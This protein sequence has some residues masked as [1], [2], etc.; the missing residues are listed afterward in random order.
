MAN[1]SP[2][3]KATRIHAAVALC[4]ASCASA[5]A[6][7]T[8]TEI[9]I[10]DKLPARVSGFGDVSAQELPFSTT[11]ITSATLQ[12]IGAQR[13]SDA[14]RLDAS[15]SDSYNSPAY[16]DILSVRGFTLDNRYNYRREGLPI[17]AETMIPMDN[18][19]R[20]E[21]LKGTS[22]IQAGTSSPGGLVNYVVKRAPTN[23][24]QQIR[25]ITLSYGQ[26]NNGLVAADL[27]GRFGETAEFGYRLNIAHED[28][29]PYIRNTKGQRNL[30]ALAMDWRLK[31]GTVVDFEFEQSHREQIGINGYSLL[32]GILPSPVDP[33]VNL[34]R[35]SWSQ[36]GVFDAMTG[37]IRLRQE[38]DAGWSWTTQYGAQRLKT[39]DRLAFGFG[40]S[41]AGDYSQYCADGSFDL[42]DFR[43]ENERRLTDAFQTQLSGK[44]KLG[45]LQ[46]DLVLGY[47]RQRQLD[48]MPPMQSYNYNATASVFNPFTSTPSPSYVT[49]NTNRSEY[50]TEFSIKDRM[51]LSTATSLWTGLRHVNYSRSSEQNEHADPVLGYPDLY[52]NAKQFKGSINVPWIAVSTQLQGLVAYAS[53]GH[54]VE[55]FVTPNTAAYGPNAGAQLGIGRSRQTEVGLRNLHAQYKLEWSAAVFQISRP[56]AHDLFDGGNYSTR[57]IDGTQTH[58]G[59]DIGA[60]WQKNQWKLSTQ[61][62]WMY[63]KLS[64]MQLSPESAGS[65]PLNVPKF[66]LRGMVEYRYASMPGLRTGLRISHEGERNVTEDER[67]KLP[68]WTTL[69]AS[70]HYDTKINNVASTWTL[71]I[72]NIEDKRYW[73]ESPKQ[74]G[75]YYLYPGAPRTIRATVQFRL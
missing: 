35:Q 23:A 25:N 19:E 8:A 64:G 3:L 48:R 66:V 53:H 17:S 39:D 59:L 43:S 34:T 68:S 56:Y 74:F 40:C 29:N 75:H 30:F 51:H 52:P 14:L 12:D 46:H 47:S 2:F 24:E 22:G 67:V 38:L 9:T 57:Y 13:V 27:G 49:P 26:G 37:S 36:P 71:A 5:W 55:Q 73:R 69:D 32:G 42:Y 58:Q 63:S 6:Q 28:L 45:N 54:G 31:P 72:D 4:I 61:T 20:I 7:Q 50:S 41:A 44:L 10:T 18:K 15:V 11:T 1:H 21:L 33:R 65:K 62:Q 70:T 16:W 60:N